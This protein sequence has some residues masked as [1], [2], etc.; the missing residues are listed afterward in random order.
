MLQLVLAA[1]GIVMP[2]MAVL[3]WSQ[4]WPIG[5]IDLGT[6]VL[7]LVGIAFAWTCCRHSTGRH[8]DFLRRCSKSRKKLPRGGREWRTLHLVFA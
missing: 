7:V 4:S 1:F 8:R 2:A 5:P 3:R 6:E